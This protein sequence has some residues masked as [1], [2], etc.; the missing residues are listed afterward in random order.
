MYDVYT[1]LGTTTY[2]MLPIRVCKYKV[3]C[4]SYLKI[5]FL[6]GS[7]LLYQSDDSHF[8]PRPLPRRGEN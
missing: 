1:L 2:A 3:L 5:P 4:S 8:T 6:G 7:I